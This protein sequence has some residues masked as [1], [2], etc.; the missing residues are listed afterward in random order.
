MVI[1]I[2][3]RRGTRDVDVDGLCGTVGEFQFQAGA[4]R[5]D[6]LSAYSFRP[7]APQKS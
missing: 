6:A 4:F 2:G 1:G 7:W 5:V 3:S